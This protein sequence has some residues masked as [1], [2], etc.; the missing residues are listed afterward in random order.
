MKGA[1]LPI[2]KQD[3][4]L[5]N[6]SERFLKNWH[7][8]ACF[9]Y[10]YAGGNW[11]TMRAPLLWICIKR[12]SLIFFLF[13]AGFLQF[14][15]WAP[16]QFKNKYQRFNKLGRPCNYYHFR[17]LL[18]LAGLPLNHDV[19]PKLG[20]EAQ[21]LKAARSPSCWVLSD[22][23]CIPSQGKFCGVWSTVCSWHRW[24][25]NQRRHDIAVGS[26]ISGVMTS[27]LDQNL[28]VSLTSQSRIHRARLWGVF[29]I[30]FILHINIYRT[31]WCILKNNNFEFLISS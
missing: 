9:R 5:Q 7:W 23:Y 20:K 19:R 29:D 26:I 30:I 4:A 22:C 18:I 24:V 13:L 28:A 11:F 12:N 14:K 31:E 1:R 6:K 16:F 27:P 25:N 21:C 3:G 15:E 10:G 17:H 8:Y 2:L